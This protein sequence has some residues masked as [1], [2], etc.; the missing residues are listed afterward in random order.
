MRPQ[1]TIARLV[2]IVGLFASM[3]SP[4]AAAVGADAQ[5]E[6]RPDG[7]S[8]V[9]HG[10]TW[11]MQTSGE[12]VPDG[13]EVRSMLL[14]APLPSLSHSP[15]SEKQRIPE[16]FLTHSLCPLSHCDRIC[17]PR[18]YTSQWWVVAD[19]IGWLH[20][21]FFSPSNPTTNRWAPRTVTVP[22][23]GGFGTSAANQ[24]QEEEEPRRHPTTIYARKE[25][26]VASRDFKFAA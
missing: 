3:P 5:P 17:H 2:I 16:T 6:P 4:L 15:I 25:I 18:P 24:R 7:R 11:M 20:Q 10:S 26:R 23:I 8:L 14:P 19:G 12:A 9:R 13:D 1:S 22:S 21:R